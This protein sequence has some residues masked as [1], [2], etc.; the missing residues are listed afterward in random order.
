MSSRPSVLSA[1]VASLVALLACGC[2][3]PATTGA[4]AIVI[5][6]IGPRPLRT[7]VAEFTLSLT[8]AAARAMSGA[9]VTLEGTMSHPGMAPVFGE[10][11]EIGA[12]RYQGRLNLTMG[13]DWVLLAHVTLA[14]GRTVVQQ[15][16]LERVRTP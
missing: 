3:G 12:G 10:T 11:R 6:E 14:N 16:G 5:T 15:V 4:P 7:G 1:A 9:R 2:S 8:D 13:G